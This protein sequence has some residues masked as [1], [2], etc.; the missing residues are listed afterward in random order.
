[1]NAVI[2]GAG[3]IGRG[4]IF[5]GHVGNVFYIIREICRW[6]G[7]VFIYPAVSDAC[8]WRGGVNYF[9]DSREFINSRL[10][11]HVIC[12]RNGKIYRVGL[13][14]RHAGGFDKIHHKIRYRNTAD[15]SCL[16]N[17][18]AYNVYNIKSCFNSCGIAA[19]IREYDRR[20]IPAGLRH[21]LRR[22]PA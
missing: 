16:N 18:F 22:T 14:H 10:E 3:K 9:H 6:N 13:A 20:I 5:Y 21:F 2:I 19:R 17:K 15:R 11:G 7:L 1:M 4:F 8:R 12:T